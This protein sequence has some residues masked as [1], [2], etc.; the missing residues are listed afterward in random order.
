[1]RVSY[2]VITYNHESYIRDSL[3][4]AF[5]QDYPEIEFIIADDASTDRTQA[6]IMEIIEEIGGDLDIKT[7]LRK[8]NAGLAENIN[9]ALSLATGEILIFQSGDDIALENRTGKVVQ[10]F[11]KDSGIQAV[12][13]DSAIID[14]NGLQIREAVK[15]WGSFEYT[16]NPLRMLAGEY[17]KFNGCTEAVRAKLL[18]KFGAIP[19]GTV[20]EDLCLL[21]RALSV[22]KV[23]FIGESL[24]LYR[25][26][27]QNLDGNL[28]TGDSEERFDMESARVCKNVERTKIFINS[29][30]RDF[31]STGPSKWKRWF[32]KN[33]KFQ[34]FC[35]LNLIE[36]SYAKKSWVLVTICFLLSNIRLF[37]KN[38]DLLLVRLCGSKRYK[39]SGRLRLNSGL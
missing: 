4:A 1:M 2:I 32:A 28:A 30:F 3:L 12:Y 7:S 20:Y 18:S 6:V 21:F 19:E 23:S 13:S 25:I 34:G 22:G 17:P 27:G 26:H 31:E 37:R 14:G 29:A 39:L 16:Y 24:L 38:L 35:H 36:A 15:G 33:K 11:K 8:K 5:S 10:E 9:D